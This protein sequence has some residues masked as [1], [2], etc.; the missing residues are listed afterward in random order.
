MAQRSSPR[1]RSVGHQRPP[2]NNRNRIAA[3]VLMPQSV[4]R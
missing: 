1:P 2:T 3:E 4:S